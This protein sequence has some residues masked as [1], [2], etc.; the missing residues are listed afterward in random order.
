MALDKE[1]PA[2]PK[3]FKV[4]YE[5]STSEA[6]FHGMYEN[7][8]TAGLISSEGAGVLEGRAFNDLS[9]QNAIWSGDSITI[10]RKPGDRLENAPTNQLP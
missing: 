3:E 4:L 7:L 6:L 1:G 9:K 10:D 5:D 8:S 2:K